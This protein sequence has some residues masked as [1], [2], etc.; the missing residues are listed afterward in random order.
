MT[1]SEPA[2]GVVELHGGV[3]LDWRDAA[4]AGAGVAPVS[5]PLDLPVPAAPVTSWLPA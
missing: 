3:V 4:E 1:R 5:G 2:L